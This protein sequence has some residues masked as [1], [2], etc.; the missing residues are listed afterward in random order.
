ME[1]KILSAQ[2][3]I[4]ALEYEIFTQVRQYIKGFV[5]EIQDV[6]KVVA[7]VDVF[8]SFALVSG[9]NDYVRPVFNDEHIIHIEA[10]RHPVVEEV[11]SKENY[12][13]NDVS[14]GEDAKIML[15][16]GPNMGG[17]STYMRQNALL[18]IMAQMGSFIPA[19]EASLP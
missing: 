11:I 7:K 15:I 6:A 5:H 16:T 10:G 13:K 2:D 3:R 1:N 9:R 17:K 8:T 19:K 14:L 4:V 18:V 12:V